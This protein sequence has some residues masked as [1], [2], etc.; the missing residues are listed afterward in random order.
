MLP[1]L[2]KIKNK[3]RSH[4][5]KI[6]NNMGFNKFTKDF[7]IIY[8]N[9]NLRGKVGIIFKLIHPEYS[10]IIKE[11]KVDGKPLENLDQ[12]L[13][14]KLYIEEK[15][16]F[17]E[18][19]TLWN[20][21]IKE[22]GGNLITSESKE[23]ALIFIEEYVKKLNCIVD[24]DK[25]YKSQ[26]TL[27][28]GKISV[29]ENI[30]W[31]KTDTYNYLIKC[32]QCIKKIDEYNNLKAYIEVLK[33]LI[34]TTGKLKEL[35]E[36]IETLDTSRIRVVLS[37]IESFKSIKNRFLELDK[38]V[39]RLKA[40]CPIAAE[41]IISRSGVC[42]D[43]FK[44]WKNSWKWAKWNSLLKDIYDL[45]FDL[46]EKDIEAEK[47]KEKHIIKEIVA[48]KTWY[49][50]IIRTTESQK[51]SLFTWMEA[52]KR[53]GKGT[54]KQAAK[55]RKIAQKEM[56]NCKDVIPVWIMPINKVMENLKL[57]I[58]YLM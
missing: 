34:L 42:E 58:I 16:I 35:N 8:K 50:Q 38:L 56:E 26:L 1:M 31:Y 21:T 4:D 29:P 33:K 49:N 5:V 43:D 37:K 14:V 40:V 13:V 48:K 47:I 25:K 53:I 7:D 2:S 20:D 51:R 24:W 36:A 57:T 52:I 30:N 17:K 54:G 32:V 19:K 44:D 12:A 28:L 55:Y 46:I 27:L 41:K 9:L 11:C 3:L 15:L 39:D 23:L 45:N 10:Y 18:L 22:C 6:P